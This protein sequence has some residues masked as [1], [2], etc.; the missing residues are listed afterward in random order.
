MDNFNLKKFLVENKLTNNSRLLEQEA[1]QPT[2]EEAA[3]IVANNTD[4]IVNSPEVKAAAEK[5]KKDPKAMKE[6]EGILSKFNIS[7]NE[8]T[9]TVN[10][11]DVY[12]LAKAFAQEAEKEAEEGLNE[13]GAAGSLGFL[14]FFG[15]GTLAHY[16]YSVA[17]PDFVGGL[18]SHSSAM[19]ETMIGAV[20]GAVVLAIAGAVIDSNK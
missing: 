15:G 14:G 20:I 8:N 2:P 9:D 7:L 13:E 11:Q 10:P 12:K 6:L 19:T 4:K 18:V 16:L 1:V 3:K 17:T 5:I